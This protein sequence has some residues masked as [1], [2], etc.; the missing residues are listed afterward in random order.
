MFTSEGSIILARNV[1]QSAAC[2][3]DMHEVLHHTLRA[4]SSRSYSCGVTS[5]LG[6]EE[7]GFNTMSC[8]AKKYQVI[9][10]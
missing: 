3:G 7:G 4:A 9:C 2:T 6:A 8:H 1:T 5:F 10:H